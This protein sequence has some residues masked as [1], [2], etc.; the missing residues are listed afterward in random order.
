[1]IEGRRP[2]QRGAGSEQGRKWTEKQM[3][4]VKLNPV[5]EQVSGKIGDIV[6]KRYED[7][8]IMTRTPNRDGLVPTVGQTDHRERFRQ[9]AA[10]GK[11]AFA[12]PARKALY[13]TAGKARR[14]PAFA[15]TVSDFLNPPAVDAIDLSGYTGQ[16]GET[17][18]VRASDDFAVVGVT[19]ALR[20]AGG[21]IIEQGGARFEL[22]LWRYV[23][24]VALPNGRAA[25]I[26]ATATDGPGNKTSR[27]QPIA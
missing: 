26:E 4:K 21:A 2:A 25:S 5:M 9:A 1:M 3:A 23:T 24:T 11:A 8:V 19:V 15:L 12:D 13:E 10:Y 22:G 7:G 6:F 20:D 17:V 18:T 16:I 27:V 14:K